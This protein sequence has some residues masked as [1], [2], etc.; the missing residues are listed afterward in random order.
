[1]L[2]LTAECLGQEQLNIKKERTVDPK[3]AG[4]IRL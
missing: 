4:D 2:L 3:K 1:M